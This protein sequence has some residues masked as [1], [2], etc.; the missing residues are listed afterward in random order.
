MSEKSK[1]KSSGKELGFQQLVGILLRKKWIVLA[2][3]L[4]C[5]LVMLLVSLFVI[6][7]KYE[8]SALFYVNNSS[9]SLGDVG[10]SSGDISARKGLV[11]SYLVI[12]RS[13]TTLEQVLDYA[14]VDM[15]TG[16]LADIIS[17]ESVENT[18]IFQVTVTH[19]DPYVAE[20][21]ASAIAEILPKRIISIIENTSAKIVDTAIVPNA[22]SS[23]SYATNTVLGLL[24]GLVLSISGIILWA[25][26]DVVIRREEDVKQVCSYPILAA[27]PDMSVSQKGGYYSRDS[28]RSTS[29]SSGKFAILVGPGISFSASEAYKLLRTKLQFSFVD[30]AGC[31]VIGISSSLAGEGKSLTSI[32]L[33]C[34]LSQ[35][36]KRVLLVDC[37]MRR[38]S[39]SAK[40][41]IQ[42]VPGLSNFLTH[43]QT[44]D[45]V[46]QN[47][48]EGDCSFDV[49]SAGRNPPNPIELLS[50]KRMIEVLTKLRSNYDYIL[51]DLPPVGEV[52]DAMVASKL[53]DGVL[54]VVRQN[55]C[56]RVSLSEA[57]DQFRFVDA[58]MLGLVMNC[59]GEEWGQYSRHYY[60]RGQRRYY[61]QYENSPIA[62]NH[63]SDRNH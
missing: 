40:L 16:E 7:P 8:S 43:Q 51:L 36:D 33:A 48:T 50:S 59:T 46:V 25:L 53:T 24:G 18:E 29:L 10:I 45:E 17:A 21:L 14:D 61:H 26:F 20:R 47:Y 39:L 37:D 23:P 57:L 62:G 52:S 13:R 49:I 2:C 12:L 6:T 54:L 11:D 56:D 15:S 38:P 9:L 31:R 60:T 27:V 34:S 42:K 44:F 22:P 1:E 55:Y 32:N 4:L 58:R 63:I 41:P 19:P 30:D 3:S 35:L 5:A 28:K